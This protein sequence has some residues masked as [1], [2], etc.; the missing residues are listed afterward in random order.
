[1]YEEKTGYLETETGRRDSLPTT[2]VVKSERTA[3]VFVLIVDVND[4]VGVIKEH[5]T[6]V[7]LFEFEISGYYPLHM[8]QQ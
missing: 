7:Y 3:A 2:D 8:M 6:N 4:L 1:M 5:E